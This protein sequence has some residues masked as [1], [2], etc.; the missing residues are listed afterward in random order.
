MTYRVP[1]DPMKQSQFSVSL[2]RGKNVDY[3]I[4]Y[5]YDLY[6]KIQNTSCKVELGQKLKIK[7]NIVFANKVF[8]DPDF[9]SSDNFT[10]SFEIANRQIPMKHVGGGIF[11]LDWTPQTQGL[12][13]IGQVVFKNDWLRIKDSISC[14]VT[15]PVD[16]KIMVAPL[17]L[18]EWNGDGVSVTQCGTLDASASQFL[19]VV[20][21]DCLLKSVPK[22][23]SSSCK[24]ITDGVPKGKE[25]TQWEVCLTSPTCCAESFGPLEVQLQ[26]KS[27]HYQDRSA[28]TNVGFKVNGT[29]FWNCWK[30]WI[31]GGLCALLLVII[32]YGYKSPHNFEDGLYITIAESKRKLNRGDTY[33][34]ADQ[35]NGKRGFFRNA[36]IAIRD[37]DFVRDYKKASLAVSAG[38]QDKL[39]LLR[40]SVKYFNKRKSTWHELSQS[41]LN[42]GLE[43]DT[44]YKTSD[45]LYFKF[46]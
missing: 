1:H 19:D 30:Y 16:L 9:F 35:I 17:D 37:L 40:G 27:T 15:G 23:F 33:E 7:S 44:I 24:P 31:I 36:R 29:S 6:T 20:E 3:G 12:G 42:V 11:E 46:S 8:D 45:D 22:G 18:G 38:P 21:T 32:I 26:P 39:I 2:T 14:D 13:M 41:D 28:Q 5:R 43:K 25:P 10:A 4:I 34:C